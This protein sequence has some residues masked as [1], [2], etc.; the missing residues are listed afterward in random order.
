MKSH[1]A[2]GRP[3]GKPPSDWLDPRGRKRWPLI[4]AVV[5]FAACLLS[6]ALLVL[7]I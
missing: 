7:L 4:E 6:T 2:D 1:L 3:I 5:T